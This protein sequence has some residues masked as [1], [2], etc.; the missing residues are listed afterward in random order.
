MFRDRNSCRFQ[1]RC[2]AES[3]AVSCG[4]RE[5][6]DLVQFSGQEAADPQLS[7][8]RRCREGWQRRLSGNYHH[9]SAPR[10]S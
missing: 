6:P 3:Q 10:K 7:D 2:P 5:V 8:L 9:P 4:Q 1:I